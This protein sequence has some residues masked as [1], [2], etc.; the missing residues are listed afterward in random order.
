MQERR[1]GLRPT[2]VAVLVAGVL[3]AIY[4]GWVIRNVGSATPNGA[5]IPQRQPASDT[6]SAAPATPPPLD[7]F[8]TALG[9]ARTL[10]V[11]GDATGDEP[12]EWVD[13]WAQDLADSRRVTLHQYDADAAQF[14]SSSVVNGSGRPLEIWNLSYPVARV[15][16]AERLASVPAKPGAVILNFGHDRSRKVLRRAVNETAD[17]IEER[18][19]R[20][21]SAWVLQNPTGGENAQEQEDA[22]A[23]VRTMATR[24]RVP[25]ID[26]HA[27][28]LAEGSL[29]ELLVD[30]ARPDEE[31]SKVWAD[32]V[33]TALTR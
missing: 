25:V 29:Q 8:R 17:A 19:G 27:A 13:L 11:V 28:F 12:G 3:V 22:V 9:G 7:L 6:R 24:A 31:G 18:W 20:L 26:V 1:F 15:D 2:E 30:G 16:Y 23:L 10:L 33:R 4:A 14:S 5:D 32:A 21:P